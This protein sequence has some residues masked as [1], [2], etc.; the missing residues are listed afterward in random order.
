MKIL[1]RLKFINTVL[2]GLLIVCANPNA[3]AQKDHGNSLDLSFGGSN[4][5]IVD[6]L[7]S[8]I[9]FRG[10]GI[11]PSFRFTHA[12][13]RN[14]HQVE[15]AFFRKDLSAGP[16]NFFAENHR[17]KL[18]YGFYHK[19]IGAS[20]MQRPFDMHLGGSL[21]SFFCKSSFFYDMQS[22]QARSL[23]TW[24]WSHSFDLT[25]MLDYYPSDRSLVRFQAYMPLLSNVSR[26]HYSSM[27]GYDLEKNDWKIK[28]FGEN[29]IF[30]KNSSLNTNLLFQQQVGNHAYINVSWEFYYTKYSDPAVIK[31][32][33]NNFRLGAGFIF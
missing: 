25:V 14:I 9:I 5:H 7:G 1:S 18:R 16:Q 28:T 15:G 20:V 10:T 29:R 31:M 23:A 4:F 33:M 3:F 22:I 8:P 2:C 12:K 11:A 26:P 19:V 32:Y 30:P 6:E 21:A 24:Y 17:G 27:G 13:N